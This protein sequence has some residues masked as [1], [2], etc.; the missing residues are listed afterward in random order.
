MLM[1]I[2][3]LLA[4]AAFLVSMTRPNIGSRIFERIESS[5]TAV[6]RKRVLAILLISI[7]A[8]TLR[9]LAL[10]VFHVPVPRVDDEYSH[11]LLADTLLHGRLA[12]P[13]P[14][15]WIHLEALEVIMHPTYSS[16]YPPMQGV[17]LAT[18][19]LLSG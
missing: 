8:V 6:A 14:P 13:T 19:T 4:L 17:F 12:N 18:G 10:P 3:T 1:L 11:L 5:F 9:L 15:M 7:C 16:I 2:E